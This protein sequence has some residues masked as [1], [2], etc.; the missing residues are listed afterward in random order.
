MKIEWS[1]KQLELLAKMEI[2]FDYLGE[3]S[4]DQLSELYDIVPD[5]LT[6]DHAGEPTGDCNIVESLID[7]LAAVMNPRGLLA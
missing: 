6:F 2:P 1:E 5:C 7:T 4:D 3:L